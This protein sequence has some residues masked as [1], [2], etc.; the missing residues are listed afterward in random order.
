[1]DTA[2][3]NRASTA[4]EISVEPRFLPLLTAYVELS[5]LALGLGER[6]AL[7][8]T[9]AAEEILTYLAKGETRARALRVA[10]EGRGYQVSL[11]FVLDTEA[12][13]LRWLNLTSRVALDL[14]QEDLA[15]AIGL[16]IAARIV[17]RL[18]LSRHAGELRLVL[19]K[20]K[21][22]PEPAAAAALPAADPA[23]TCRA[24]DA[25]ELN[26]LLQGLHGQLGEDL[27]LDLARPGRMLDMVAAGH[28]QAC[29]AVD[30]AGRIGGGLFWR[31][32]NER[33]VECLGPYLPG[34]PSATARL[35]LEHL[36]GR[37]ARSSCIG[38]LNRHP[39]PVL[40]DGFFEILG[41]L[42]HDAADG[43]ALE[44]PVHYR[45]L[46]ED[47]GAVSW[48]HPVLRAFLIEEYARLAFA[49]DLYEVADEGELASSHAVLAA[50]LNRAASEARLAPLW[51]GADAPEV[52][53]EHVRV[54]RQE[55]LRNLLME[56]DLGLSWQ[57][58]F[59]PALLDCGF[60]PRVLLPHA[61]QGD[62]LTLQHDGQGR[63]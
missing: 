20:D 35:L 38:L 12:L 56:L 51:W 53:R 7:A 16:L 3:A 41:T 40:P 33:L 31:W 18:Q 49:R 54:L 23:V 27:P 10:C 28:Y 34:Q 48:T 39:V 47:A 50:T 52:V 15:D 11:A 45:H 29:I 9:L 63:P 42:R 6:E 19:S 24:P 43:K 14:D 5:A 46:E 37:L 4:L 57:A 59:G 32:R 61:G 8:L 21:V 60:V 44:I 25:A 22:Y 58:R 1:M 62:L 13:D 2:S 36:L 30:P 17:D 55:G 26:L